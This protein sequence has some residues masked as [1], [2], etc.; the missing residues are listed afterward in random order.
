MPLSLATL[1]AAA[2]E[3]LPADL[4]RIVDEAAAET[5]RRQWTAILTRLEENYARMRAN[6]V[7]IRTEVP[8]DIAATLAK[9]AETVV[10]DWRQKAG[11]KGA[12]ILDQYRKK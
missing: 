5:E 11:S 4:Q 3:A 8:A 9:A 12:A 6:G 7:T 1:N 2:Y 10:D